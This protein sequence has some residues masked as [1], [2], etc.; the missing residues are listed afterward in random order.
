MTEPIDEVAAAY[1]VPVD[2]EVPMKLDAIARAITFPKTK[3]AGS[4]NEKAAVV[5]ALGELFDNVQAVDELRAGR[6]VP[7]ELVE[8]MVASAKEADPREVYPAT[9]L[10]E[11]VLGDV[12]AVLKAK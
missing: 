11:A 3:I 1:G 8:M 6:P 12:A 9:E 2:D 10:V 5:A 7:V 4:K